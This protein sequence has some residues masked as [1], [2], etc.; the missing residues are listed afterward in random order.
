VKLLIAEDD[1][2]ARRLMRVVLADCPLEIV[3][4]A[5][6]EEALEVIEREAPAMLV[7]DWV[8]PGRA[9][10]RSAGGFASATSPSGRTS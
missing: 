1:P 3:T 4:A 8:L 2:I 7:L 6:G 9:A 5:D 10:S